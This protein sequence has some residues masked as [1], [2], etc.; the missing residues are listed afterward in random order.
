MTSLKPYLVI[1]LLFCHY[2]ITAQ[3]FLLLNNQSTQSFEKAINSPQANFHPSI[4]PYFKE[5]INALI[6]VDSVYNSQNIFK[7]ILKKDSNNSD[8]KITI[9]PLLTGFGGIGKETNNL[10]F[11]EGAIGANI[12]GTYKDKVAFNT[13]YLSGLAR[14]PE[15]VNQQINATQI[16]PG[17]GHGHLNSDNDYNYRNWGGYL[18]YSPSKLFNFTLGHGRNFFGNGYRSLLLSDAANNY[19]YFKI[20]TS[21]G[22]FK[23]V[24]MYANFKD[25]STN[26]YSDYYSM[27]NKWGA[28]HYLSWNIA[29]WLNAGFFETVIWPGKDENMQ[30]GFDITYLNPVSFYRPAEYSI[31]SSDNSL[32]GLNLL[33]RISPKHQLYFQLMLDEFLL[34]KVRTNFMYHWLGVESTEWGWWANKQ[35]LQLGYKWFDAF[36][37][38]NLNWRLEYNFVP[39]Y[40][41]SHTG[42]LLNYGHEN[43]S[44]AHSSSANFHEFI[45]IINYQKKNW[46]VELQNMFQIIGKDTGGVNY[47]SNIYNDY[48]KHPNE[49]GNYTGQGLTS[50]ILFNQ[51][52]VGFILI[53]Q[54]NLSVEIG[55]INR[56][57]SNAINSYSTNYIFGGIKTSLFNVYRDF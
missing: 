39:P 51:V 24:Q 1:V 34:S 14:Y 48:L 8:G 41:Y 3:D 32:M 38:K 21:V 18:S 10:S 49:H 23:Y 2:E 47:G 50:K 45:S 20:T 19:S 6:N 12:L 33:A 56:T 46:Y 28:F 25:I 15:Y 57:E 40:T 17:N 44:L 27:P 9:S 37:I 13:W 43:Q 35:A 5:D 22:K 29:P 7:G 4:K 26:S 52:K 30:R 16:I 11:A 54:T 55:I 36:F 53:P 31:G 42:G